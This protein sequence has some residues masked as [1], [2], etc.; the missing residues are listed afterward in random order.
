MTST[1]SPPGWERLHIYKSREEVLAILQEHELSPEDCFY[2]SAIPLAPMV[3][4]RD[5]GTGV[6]M[7]LP[8]RSVK[9]YYVLDSPTGYYQIPLGER[10]ILLNPNDLFDYE[11]MSDL[12]FVK[13]ADIYIHCTEPY[14]DREKVLEWTDV[15]Y[16]DETYPDHFKEETHDKAE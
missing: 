3:A 2:L 6:L 9:T 10:V 5:D 7:N 14:G 4:I 15:W 13:D 12:H 11:L 16:R 8:S 1:S